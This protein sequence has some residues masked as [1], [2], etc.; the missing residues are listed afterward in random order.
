MELQDATPEQQARAARLESARLCQVNGNPLNP[1]AFAVDQ[2]Q[3]QGT[4]RVD[5]FLGAGDRAFLSR[6]SREGCLPAAQT[7]GGLLPL[8]RAIALGDLHSLEVALATGGENS[9]HPL[10]RACNAF[11]ETLLHTAVL[12]QQLGAV[13]LL[14]RHVWHQ[15]L[16]YSRML[17]AAEA[18]P[19]HYACAAGHLDILK[20]LLSVV[21]PLNETTKSWRPG[22]LLL[23]AITSI[24]P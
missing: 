3:R 17:D 6:S 1:R 9:R 16:P 14:L 21:T 10:T 7:N 13:Q 2:K 24:Q 15:E 12:H 4:R 23:W 18:T 5:S 8:Q 19:L 11:G 20:L 22:S